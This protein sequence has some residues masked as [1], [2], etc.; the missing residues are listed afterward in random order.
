MNVRLFIGKLFIAIGIIFLSSSTSYALGNHPQ[1]NICPDD[2][3]YYTFCSHSL[4][5]LEGWYGECRTTRAEAEKD[6]TRHAQEQHDGNDRW[7][8]VLKARANY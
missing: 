5:S 3:P 6:A 8:G 1:A 4:H 2:K 7:T